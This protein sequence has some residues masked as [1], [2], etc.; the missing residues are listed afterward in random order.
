MLLRCLQASKTPPLQQISQRVRTR[1]RAP[2]LTQRTNE[3]PHDTQV[4]AEGY[5]YSVSRPLSNHPAEEQVAAMRPAI[6]VGADV[7]QLDEEPIVGY[8]EG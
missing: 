1:T 7:H 8:N 3:N 5:R 6:A 2:P 4:P